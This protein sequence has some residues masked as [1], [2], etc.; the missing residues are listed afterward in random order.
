MKVPT[1]LQILKAVYTRHLSMYPKHDPYVPVD[2][3]SVAADLNCSPHMVYGRLNWLSLSRY[4]VK[5]DEVMMA[6]LF[7]QHLQGLGPSVHFPC[8]ASAL[9]EYQER[10]STQQRALRLSIASLILS[11]IAVVV[12]VFR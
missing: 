5:Q 10:H 2:L 12:N 6:A 4:Q 1:D 3:E 7:A 9:A 8:L 11:V